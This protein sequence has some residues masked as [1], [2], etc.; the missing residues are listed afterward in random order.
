MLSRAFLFFVMFCCIVAVR[1]GRHGAPHKR[2]TQRRASQTNATHLQ[3][4]G[5]LA[6]EEL[7]TPPLSLPST[8]ANAS[9]QAGIG[10]VWPSSPPSASPSASPPNTQAAAGSN[11]AQCQT[12]V[13]GMLSW[14][15]SVL[16]A[17]RPLA[18]NT[19]RR[20]CNPVRY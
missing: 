7:C 9:I 3:I 16:L 4:S 5:L 12:E 20:Q 2:Q 6:D 8:Q 14:Q 1:R 10:L 15:L 17:G 11:E 13:S 19:L 18:P